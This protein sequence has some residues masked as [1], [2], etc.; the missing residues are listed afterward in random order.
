[1]SAKQIYCLVNIDARFEVHLALII[2]IS[3]ITGSPYSASCWSTGK[4]QFGTRGHWAFFS[5][6]FHQS[7]TCL[8]GFDWSALDVHSRQCLL[9]IQRYILFDS[10][11][12]HLLGAMAPGWSKLSS[13]LL[14]C[15]QERL[16]LTVIWWFCDLVIP[17]IMGVNLTSGWQGQAGHNAG[18][19]PYTSSLSP[20]A[21]WHAIVLHILWLQQA[22]IGATSFSV[23]LYA[24]SR[25]S[26]EISRFLVTFRLILSGEIHT[27]LYHEIETWGRKSI[28]NNTIFTKIGHYLCIQFFR[29]WFLRKWEDDSA[30]VLAQG[31][32]N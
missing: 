19:T 20:W 26:P 24:L 8:V 9:H 2:Q 7:S 31:V 10:P 14:F 22:R 16:M 29:S 25:S 32:S 17:R 1:M 13:Y 18:A 3:Y 5:Q 6:H 30:D 15:Q 27:L 4:Q 28:E 21:C 23:D 12:L 11:P